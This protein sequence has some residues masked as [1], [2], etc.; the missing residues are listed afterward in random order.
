MNKVTIDIDYP[1][2]LQTILSTHELDVTRYLYVKFK[3]NG[4]EIEIDDET[5]PITVTATLVSEDNILIAQDVSTVYGTIPSDLGFGKCTKLNLAPA[6]GAYRVRP[7]KMRVEFALTY[8]NVSLNTV[9][10][11]VAPLIVRVT[12]SIADN[13][14]IDEQSI[15]SYAEA[16]RRI[17]AIKNKLSETTD[18]AELVHKIVV[19]GKLAGDYAVY[20]NSDGQIYAQA[21]SNPIPSNLIAVYLPSTFTTVDISDYAGKWATMPGSGIVIRNIIIDNAPENVDVR[22][23]STTPAPTE[24]YDFVFFTRLSQSY[25]KSLESRIAA[26][27]NQE[28]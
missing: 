14:E 13:A 1:Y 7:G 25:L 3:Q 2:S 21:R 5:N 4:K 9:L 20:V 19:L 12:P 23:D 8:D 24:G 28:G 10:H 6:T 17:S 27:E 15:G 16:V 18:T 22:Y 26:L 11:P